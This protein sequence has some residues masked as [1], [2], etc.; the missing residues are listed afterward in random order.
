MGLLTLVCYDSTRN[1]HTKLKLLSLQLCLHCP[2]PESKWDSVIEM[3]CYCNRIRGSPSRDRTAIRDGH[4]KE[5]GNCPAL[6]E[7]KERL[8][9]NV[10]H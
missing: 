4:P 9:L 5:D 6:P 3:I 2:K 7:P 8:A 10:D 1:A